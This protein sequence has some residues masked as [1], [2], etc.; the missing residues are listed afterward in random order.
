MGQ[1][2]CTELSPTATN[3]VRGLGS[4]LETVLRAMTW[5]LRISTAPQDPTDRLAITG[6]P[7]RWHLAD[8]YLIEYRSLKRTESNECPKGGFFV[9]NLILATPTIRTYMQGTK[10]ITWYKR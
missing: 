5:D 2:A 9:N 10:K 8:G 3:V 4:V 6:A 7:W 1:P